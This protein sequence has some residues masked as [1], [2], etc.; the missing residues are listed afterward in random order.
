MK[1]ML[2]LEQIIAALGQIG[3]FS[4]AAHFIKEYIT[5]SSAKDI[6]QYKNELKM[7]SDN[8]SLILSN[9]LE[10]YKAELE[11][12]INRQGKLYQERLNV[13]KEM[14]ELL[15]GLY[16]LTFDEFYKIVNN[17]VLL[18]DFTQK[19]EKVVYECSSY[20][21][22]NALFFKLTQ[23]EKLTSLIALYD[24]FLKNE[25]IN[26]SSGVGRIPMEVATPET[27]KLKIQFD[28]FR[29]ELYES[30]IK[31]LQDLESDFRKL[32]GV[33]D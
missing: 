23:Y 5:K 33:E 22:K 10:R 21:K 32:L 16:N 11:I 9:E 4:I 3:V 20:A 28:Q 12:N 24:T 8:H 26:A 6:E 13:I 1:R 25:H 31:T 19:I 27:K 14:H 15:N 29:N 18:K 2:M 30:L 17:D 7:L